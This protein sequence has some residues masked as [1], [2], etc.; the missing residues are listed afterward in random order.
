VHFTL[1]TKIADGS[2]EMK[3]ITDFGEGKNA[4][5]DK[6]KSYQLYL[7]PEKNYTYA[8]G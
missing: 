4:L 3:K 2:A 5:K 1:E 8:S 7:T 6:M